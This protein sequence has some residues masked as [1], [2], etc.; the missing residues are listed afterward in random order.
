MTSISCRSKSCVISNGAII[1]FYLC[2][3]VLIWVVIET[4]ISYEAVPDRKQRGEGKD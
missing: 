4:L 2:S 1:L 3:A